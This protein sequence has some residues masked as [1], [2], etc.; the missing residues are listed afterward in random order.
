MTIYRV[1][2]T[3]WVATPRSAR[4]LFVVVLAL[5]VL[6]DVLGNVLVMSTRVWALNAF[7]VGAANAMCW[8]LLLPNGLLL[9]LAARRLRLP[10]IGRDVVWSLLL[11]AALGIGVPLLCQFPR[12]YVLSFALVQVLVAAGAMLF[13]MMPYYLGMALYVL[14][15]IFHRALGHFIALPGPSDARFVPWSAAFAVVLVLTL[16]WRWGQMLR[17]DYATQGVRAPSLIFF[18]RVLI[19]AQRDLLT[20]PGSIGVRP[21]WLIASPPL[22]DVGPQAPVKA[23]RIALGGVYLPQTLMGS[24]YQVANTALIAGFCGMILFFVP[25]EGTGLSQL[26]HGLFAHP[27]FW[28]ASW[29]F[30]MVAL[31]VVMMPVELLTLRWGRVNAELPLLALLPG[32][33]RAGSSKR[34]LLR[35][36]FEQ[37]AVRFGLLL[38]VGWLGVAG[39]HVGWQVALAMLVVAVGCLGYL[40]AMAVSI[41]GGRPLSDFG[42][43]LLLLGMFVL[44]SATM[45]LPQLD[46]GPAAQLIARASDVLVA[47]WLAL[48]LFLWWLARRG[49]RALH[50]RPHPFLAR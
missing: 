16:A 44:L 5:L 20:D 35:T 3:P 39:L 30:A 11:Y 19:G 50:H 7:V 28:L 26:L 4:W 21:G 36:V 38:L 14:F 12:G 43:S 41:F 25:F 17:G 45:L 1:L 6:G 40:Y 29:M 15:L 13:L 33:G 22:R 24:L 10:R 42:K 37:A 23:L 2:L 31:G 49:G 34:L 18:R 8:L 32:L 9:A 46:D 48:A 47:A 27:R